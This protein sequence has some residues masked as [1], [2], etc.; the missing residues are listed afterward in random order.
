MRQK[1][2]PIDLC[3]PIRAVFLNIKDIKMIKISF[4]MWLGKL[5]EKNP[6]STLL[7]IPFVSFLIAIIIIEFLK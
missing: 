1:N 4:F 6:Y 3:R 2:L 7:A 5:F